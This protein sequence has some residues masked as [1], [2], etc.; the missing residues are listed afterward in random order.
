MIGGAACD[1]I[2]EE[3]DESFRATKDLDLVLVAEAL[4]PEFGDAFRQFIVNGVY[5][6]KCKSTG[7]PQFYR[8]DKPETAG[9]PYMPELDELY[10]DSDDT[11]AFIA[12]YTIRYFKVWTCGESI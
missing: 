9:Y 11:F 4:T 5:R 2:L 12:G 1:I 8:F 10:A 7:S 3:S 6:N